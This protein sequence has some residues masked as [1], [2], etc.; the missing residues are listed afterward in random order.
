MSLY[1]AVQSASE[2]GAPLKLPAPSAVTLVNQAA[3]ARTA[4]AEVAATTSSAQATE[5][6]LR[7]PQPYRAFWPSK[8]WLVVEALPGAAHWRRRLVL[9]HRR[10]VVRLREMYQPLLSS[11]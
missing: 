2:V 6:N 7:S 8:H 9:Q 10:L 4:L 5:L 1:R 3:L 11:I